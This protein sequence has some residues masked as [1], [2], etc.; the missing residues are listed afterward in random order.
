MPVMGTH[1]EIA[2]ALKNVQNASAEFGAEIPA[3]KLSLEGKVLYS[4]TEIPKPNTC[5]GNLH[6]AT[7][8]PNSH[9]DVYSPF[10]NL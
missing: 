5:Q 10:L 9:Q 3:S 2:Q 6:P 8:P 7:T 1:G 4:E